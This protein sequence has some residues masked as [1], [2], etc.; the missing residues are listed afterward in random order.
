MDETTTTPATS[1]LLGA[2]WSDPLE[3]E[4]RG[5]PHDHVTFAAPEIASRE[6]P[7]LPRRHPARH[8]DAKPERLR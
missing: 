5:R 8:R 3:D 7:P 1:P 2:G 6:F 4:V